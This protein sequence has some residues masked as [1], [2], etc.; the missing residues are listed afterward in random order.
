MGGTHML[1]ETR[2]NNLFRLFVFALAMVMQIT[3]TAGA[4]GRS[5]RNPGQLTGTWRL[6]VS[7]SDNTEDAIE[8]AIR[9]LPTNEQQRARERLMRKL[10]APDLIAIEQRGRRFTIASTR[11]PQTRFDADG[12]TRTETTERGR[13]IRINA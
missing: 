12:R 8:R 4:Q 9:R 3:L 2:S 11:A 5:Q 6:E 7:S 13:T 10:D 1:I